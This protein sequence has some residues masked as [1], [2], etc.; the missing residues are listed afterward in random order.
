MGKAGL[1]LKQMWDL[2]AKSV[3][4]WVDDYARESTPM[5]PNDERSYR[6]PM[7]VSKI[8]IS[9]HEYVFF[10]P[11]SIYCQQDGVEAKNA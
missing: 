3:E 2:T 4:A 8:L 10:F 6:E 1:C 11:L 5:A 9:K 7:R